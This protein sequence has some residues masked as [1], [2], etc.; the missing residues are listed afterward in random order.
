MPMSAALGFEKLS[1]LERLFRAHHRRGLRHV[2]VRRRIHRRDGASLAPS[3]AVCYCHRLQVSVVWPPVG[4]S[5]TCVFWESWRFAPRSAAAPRPLPEPYLAGYTPD[6]L[7]ELTPAEKALLAKGFAKNLKDPDSAK[8]EWV[9]IPKNWSNN[10]GGFDYCATLN[11]KNSYGGYI[12]YQPFIAFV[13]TSGTKITGG[14]TTA[15]SGSDAT[16]RQIVNDMC[17]KKGLDPSPR[18]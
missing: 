12:G 14:Y 1:G 16:E 4:G 7:R 11:A 6:E 9:K 17:A 13:M 2:L 8:F 3:I 18:Q 10:G 5:A 15:V